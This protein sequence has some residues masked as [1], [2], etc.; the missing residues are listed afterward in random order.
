[1]T[2]ILSF[3]FSFKEFI[4]NQHFNRISCFRRN[5]STI[6]NIESHPGRWDV[7]SSAL[8]PGNGKSRQNAWYA[9]EFFSREI[10]FQISGS[11][12]LT[13]QAKKI[14]EGI[15]IVRIELPFPIWCTGMITFFLII[16]SNIWR[17]QQ[18]VCAGDSIH[19][20]EVLRRE[21]SFNPGLQV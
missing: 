17:M 20:G 3:I 21:V 8:A 5:G 9:I 4:R 16:I 18:Q 11:H 2:R 7:L 14:K 12:H 19:R 13:H 15:L 10:S 1:M 6:D